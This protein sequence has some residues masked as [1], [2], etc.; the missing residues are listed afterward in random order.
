MYSIGEVG[1]H[2]LLVPRARG[3]NTAPFFL[4]LLGGVLRQG[5]YLECMC[6]ISDFYSIHFH[7]KIGS[8]ME[9]EMIKGV[10]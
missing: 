1:R 9:N 3:G 8:L 6:N 7:K 5:E 10:L 4:A 2:I